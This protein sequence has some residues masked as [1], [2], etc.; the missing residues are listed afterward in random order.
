MSLMSLMRTFTVLLL[1]HFTQARSDDYW[2][3][4]FDEN[5]NCAR[6][7]DMKELQR[8]TKPG[9]CASAIRSGN[10]ISPFYFLIIFLSRISENSVGRM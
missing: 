1:V 3:E 5:K 8:E 6:E 4:D 2:N 10:I 9:R 7:R